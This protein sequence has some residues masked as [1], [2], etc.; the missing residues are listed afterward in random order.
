MHPLYPY[1]CPILYWLAGRRV[2]NRRKQ[3]VAWCREKLLVEGHVAVPRIQLHYWRPWIRFGTHTSIILLW[4]RWT[5]LLHCLRRYWV[6]RRS[7]LP[8]A[9]ECSGVLEFDFLAIQPRSRLVPVTWL[10]FLV[11]SYFQGFQFNRP[12]WDSSSGIPIV[13]YIA[14]WEVSYH[15]DLVLIKVM[16]EFPGGD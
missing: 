2:E 8:N 16:P 12:L 3:V 4:G 11:W 5:K 14:Q 1:W 10:L 9:L 15:W 6:S 13:E 7:T